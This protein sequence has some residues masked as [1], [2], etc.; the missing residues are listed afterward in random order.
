MFTGRGGGACSTSVYKA[1]DSDGD[2][3]RDEQEIANST[4][5]KDPNDPVKTA[6]PNSERFV[7]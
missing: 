7:Q 2:G 1:C 5:P 4:N 6:P 3:I